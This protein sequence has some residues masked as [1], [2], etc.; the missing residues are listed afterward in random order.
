MAPILIY[1]IETAS[2]NPAFICLPVGDNLLNLGWLTPIHSIGHDP[3]VLRS[4]G[5]LLPDH[6]ARDFLLAEEVLPDLLG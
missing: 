6:I 1:A 3:P 4:V 2:F 5:R